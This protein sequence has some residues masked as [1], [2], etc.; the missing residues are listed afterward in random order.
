MIRSL[1]FGLLLLFSMMISLVFLPERCRF[2]PL[3][4]EG[5]LTGV[6]FISSLAG[7]SA[8]SLTGA[9]FISS[10][11]GSSALSLTGAGFSSSEAVSGSTSSSD[12]YCCS[13]SLAGSMI[14][15]DSFISSEAMIGSGSTAGSGTGSITSSG[16][17]L[18]FSS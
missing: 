14:G 12:V 13:A 7:W 8:S 18:D 17:S 5:T 3:P 15:S 4:A 2:L 11:A 1:G 6:G 16:S 9:G 10:S